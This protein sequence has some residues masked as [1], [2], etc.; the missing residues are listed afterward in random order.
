MISTPTEVCRFMLLT[1]H[2]QSSAAHASSS[3]AC[4]VQVTHP[5]LPQSTS[6]SAGDPHS[7]SS[8]D[9]SEE[10]DSSRENSG[11]GDSDE[12]A[13]LKRQLAASQG[14]L[15]KERQYVEKCEVFA[16]LISNPPIEQ[17]RANKIMAMSSQCPWAKTFFC[18]QVPA[19]VDSIKCLDSCCFVCTSTCSNCFCCLVAINVLV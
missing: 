9:S 7:E 18:F 11:W 6:T 13:E 2:G 4:M 15:Q 14:A 8:S 10:S 5:P 16:L 17:L 19:S 1:L 3:Y 12:V